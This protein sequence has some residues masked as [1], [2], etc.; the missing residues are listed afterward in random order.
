[1]VLHFQLAKAIIDVWSGILYLIFTIAQ[2][3][4]GVRVFI[5]FLYSFLLLAVYF[6]LKVHYFV[7]V[8]HKDTPCIFSDEC[9]TVLNNHCFVKLC[10]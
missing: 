9:C 6:L 10:R 1:M 5:T 8:D 4:N 7:K 2:E 3:R